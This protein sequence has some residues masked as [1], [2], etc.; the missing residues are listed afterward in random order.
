MDRGAC[1]ASVHRVAKSQTGLKLLSTHARELKQSIKQ[2]PGASGKSQVILLSYSIQA[3][4]HL[5]NEPAT[6]KAL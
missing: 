2:P 4:I 6:L 3:L 1:R 5:L